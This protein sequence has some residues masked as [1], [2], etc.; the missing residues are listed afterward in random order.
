MP[1]YKLYE[2]LGLAKGAS[3]EE[4]KKSYKKKALTTHPDRGGDP[5]EFKRISNA[6]QILSDENKRK[7]Y[8]QLGDEQFQE[9]GMQGG[10]DM[11]G[12]DP[13]ILFR[14][15]F[16]QFDFGFGGGQPQGPRKRNDHLHHMKMSLEDAYRGVHKTVRISL[17]K[18]CLSAN[19]SHSCF[20]CQGR[21]SVTDMRR[22]G[23][24]T[25]MMTRP[26]DACGATG[27]LLKPKENCEE[28]KGKGKYMQDVMYE[29]DVPTGVCTGHR[30]ICPGLGEQPQSLG[31]IPG[32]LVFEVVIHADANFQ[33]Q[34]NDL[35][36][37][38]QLSF[39]ES[40]LGKIIR[41]PHFGGMIE[42]NTS[43]YGIVQP[44]KPYLLK[45][46]GMTTDSNLIV[47]FHID[48]P[49]RVFTDA[50]RETLCNAFSSVLI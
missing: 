14:D 30:I 45:G 41:I 22:M 29:L 27:K 6:Y 42:L 35:V 1:S 40:V 9:N 4:I 3:I 5:E 32:D 33:R 20:S 18:T 19:C 2:D 44:N 48:Y 39:V 8:D 47:L 7:T 24:M 23:F 49:T 17:Q 34:G 25:Q 26:C 43:D 50:E 15:L 37:T 10:G 36:F 28:C 46:K 21:G 16:S 13:N 11:G 31:E 38:T 12:I